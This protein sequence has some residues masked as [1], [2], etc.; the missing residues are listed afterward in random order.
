MP[1]PP[2]PPP[3][4]YG[5]IGLLMPLLDGLAYSLQVSFHRDI[6][7]RRCR[8]MGGRLLL[9]LGV[10]LLLTVL[11]LPNLQRGYY[12]WL[13]AGQPPDPVTLQLAQLGPY[14]MFVFCGL[15]VVAHVQQRL[16]A[17]AR[18]RQ[19]GQPVHSYYDGTPNLLRR[20]PRLGEH[21]CKLVVEP[22][23]WG[24]LGALA[25]GS[26]L[27]QPGVYMVAAGVAQFLLVAQRAYREREQALDA[28][29][30][31]Y[32]MMAHQEAVTAE[33]D[34]P[35]DHR[36]GPVAVHSPPPP[37]VPQPR[38]RPAAAPPHPVPPATPV[39]AH[40]RGGLD[41]SLNRLLDEPHEEQ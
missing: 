18:R 26:G 39:P 14:P 29:D 2:Q 34:A 41:E 30:G 32:D 22:L 24:G 17:A 10:A 36:P 15:T 20:W 40:L 23:V 37:A 6:G 7:E 21:R 38:P 5:P 16:R 8:D 12:R 28:T 13:L 9:A 3:P 35:G 31:V 11:T 25:V 33:W 19:G 27:P 1:P 4:R